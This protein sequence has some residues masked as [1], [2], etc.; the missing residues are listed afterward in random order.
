M[1][2]SKTHLHL[3]LILEWCEKEKKSRKK[4][5]ATKLEKGQILEWLFG[6][7]YGFIEAA[8]SSGWYGSHYESEEKV[9]QAILQDEHDKK[10]AWDMHPKSSLMKFM[11]GV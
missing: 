11:V 6:L 7:S 3:H 5:L 1:P 2:A 10:Q 8:Q 9:F 4:K